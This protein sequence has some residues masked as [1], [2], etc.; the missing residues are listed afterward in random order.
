MIIKHVRMAFRQITRHKFSFIVAI[1]GLA[2]SLAAVGHLVSYAL[3]YLDFDKKVE[4]HDEWYRL[5]YSQVHPELG[6]IASADFFIPPA[7]MLIRD[8]PE[9]TDHLLYWP[10]VIAM[11][12]RCDG[13]PF[14][15]EKSV[16]VSPN[17]P[18]HYKLDII[19]GDPDSLLSDRFKLL[20]SESFSKNYFGDANPV[21]KKIYVGETPRYTISGVFADMDTNLHLRH[22]IYSLWY[23]DEEDSSDS[24]DDW[25]LTGH[26]RVRIPHKKNLKIVQ[27]KLNT[28]LNEYSSMIGQSGNLKVY[29]DPIAKIHFITGLKNDAPTMSILSI[30]SI[31]AL[32][33]MFLLT[34]ISNFLIIIGLSWKKRG[35]E[36]FFRRAV[37]AGR[38]ELIHQMMCEYSLYFCIAVLLGIVLYAVTMGFFSEFIR[39]D[40]LS[41]SLFLLPYA[42]CT[43][44]A[45]ITLGLV[46][47]LIMSL[48][49]SAMALGCS[50][51]H[52]N[53]RDRG[54]TVLLYL[55]MVIGFAF[56]TLAVSLSINYSL[57]S[58]IE[59][60]WDFKNTI[61]YSYLT[62]NDDSIKGYYDAR[63]LR[64]RIREIPGVLKESVSNFDLVTTS[65]D[66]Q[67]GFHKV[68]VYLNDNQTDTPV[69]SYLCSC[70]PDFF[71]TREISILNGSI[72]D[73][74]AENM[75]VV[76]STF[77][78]RYLDNPIGSSIR[79]ADNDESPWYEVLAVVDDC[80]FFPTY[81]EM[82]PMVMILKAYMVRY[83]QISWQDGLKQDV[84]PAL[85]ELFADAASSG[86]FGYSSLEI[87]HAQSLYYVQE[88]TIKN[89]SLAMTIFVVIIAVM[90]V[91]AVSSVSI[92]SQMK[93]ISIRKICGAEFHDL[94]RLYCRK[95]LLLYLASAIPGLILAYNLIKAYTDRFAIQ[96][97]YGA[98]AYPAAIII[99][100]AIVF[101]PLYFSIQKAYRADPTRYLQAD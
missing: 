76:N 86:V 82:I 54:I 35:D 48:R 58:N 7:P 38:A 15:M 8:I 14:Q 29:L 63:L 94:W 52:R 12:L 93:D 84:L 40:L 13:K 55:Q 98:I 74:V 47:S 95:Y 44:I 10:S 51:R 42:G 100:I 5:R 6:E 59:R 75:V 65:L 22:D 37:G 101:I 60:G 3:F 73:E 2:I 17:F 57:I 53:H 11:N 21:G 33:F 89:I 91:Y 88:Q 87:E 79:I 68:Q 96:S 97:H 64:Q 36:F 70:P 69:L 9:I 4:N 62:V 26:V 19:Y 45:I 28:I 23:N 77:A 78:Q 30:Y 80:W 27:T 43:A 16:F 66:N 56:I 83:Y 85:E 34:A 90:G 31:L 61:Q 25:Y 72:P 39:V 24:E 67:N 50:T 1:L 32:S 20:I 18:K 81:H 49:H 71:R 46:S 99:M 92:H 41:Y